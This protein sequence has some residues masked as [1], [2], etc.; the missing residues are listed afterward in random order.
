[1][2]D[3]AEQLIDFEIIEQHRLRLDHVPDGDDR[4]IQAVTFFRLGIYFLRPDRSHATAQDIGADD[5]KTLG[6]QRLTRAHHVL[7]PAAAPA[8]R[9]RPE[10]E[11]IARQGM[12]HENRVGFIVI[13]D[14]VGLIGGGERAQFGPRIKAQRLVPAEFH[15]ETV[16]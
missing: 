7:P 9:M 5:M 16:G 15:T 4:K 2:G 11:L 14:A 3:N 10:D 12:T 6:I 1:M 13:E 8:D